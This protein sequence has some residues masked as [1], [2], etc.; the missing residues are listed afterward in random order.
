MTWEFKIS[1]DSI[2]EGGLKLN[3]NLPSPAQNI[4][5][6]T[7][8]SR[9]WS[10]EIFACAPATEE[11]DHPSEDEVKLKVAPSAKPGERTTIHLSD[12][13]DAARNASKEIDFDS[14]T[15]N[16]EK[17]LA[18]SARFIISGGKSLFYKDPMFNNNG[19]LIVEAGYKS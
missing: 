2:S 9:P 17:A 6:F 15:V 18:S 8:L 3:M 7:E 16:L 12:I 14:M 13:K 19:D 1:M 5:V 11:R 4:F 10:K